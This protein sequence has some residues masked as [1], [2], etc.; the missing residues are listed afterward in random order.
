MTGLPLME[1]IL[2]TIAKS[3]LIPL[4]LTATTSVQNA[5]IHRNRF[6]SG[7]RTLIISNEKIS[8]IIKIDKSLENLVYQ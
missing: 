2:K 4:I 5:A 8:G 6:R 3:V 7:M 1:N